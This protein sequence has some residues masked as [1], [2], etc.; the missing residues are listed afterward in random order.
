MADVTLSEKEYMEMK[1]TIK[2]LKD[3]GNY[4]YVESYAFHTGYLG[5]KESTDELISAIL[6][7]EKRK[8]EDI[9]TLKEEIK[10]LKKELEKKVKV[11][12]F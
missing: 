11:S 3:K 6:D 10:E 5:L 7:L 12:L 8:N 4:L 9:R 1:N 2:Q